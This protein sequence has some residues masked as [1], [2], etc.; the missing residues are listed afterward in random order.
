MAY[1]RVWAEGM[2]RAG[3]ARKRG[4]VA[5]LSSANVTSLC[6]SKKARQDPTRRRAL[7]RRD[8]RPR[9]RM[10]GQDREL[11]HVSELEPARELQRAHDRGGEPAPVH[12][13]PNAACKEGSDCT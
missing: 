2:A 11:E 3:G 8:V 13:H 6:C 12:P 9:E 1:L 4:G 7:S 5:M 10:R